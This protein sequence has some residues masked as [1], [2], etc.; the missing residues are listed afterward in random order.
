MGPSGWRRQ[1]HSFGARRRRPC[2]P[3]T[4]KTCS[5][6]CRLRSADAKQMYAPSTEQ[7]G[8]ILTLLG[9]SFTTERP[10][11]ESS[12]VFYLA[13]EFSLRERP[14]GCP[15][16]TRNYPGLANRSVQIWYGTAGRRSCHPSPGGKMHVGYSS[17]LTIFA[18][19]KRI[20]VNTAPK[21]RPQRQTHS[22]CSAPSRPR[23]LTFCDPLWKI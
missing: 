6:A 19:S 14:Q 7:Q 13:V 5:S 17:A 9:L 15:R 18:K 2:R 4:E 22:P 1:A 12:S 11:P 16:T 10:L 8:L 21:T 20:Q 3:R 23:C